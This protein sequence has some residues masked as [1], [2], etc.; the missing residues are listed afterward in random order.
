[1]QVSEGKLSAGRPAILLSVLSVPLLWFFYVPVESAVPELGDSDVEGERLKLLDSAFLCSGSICGVLGAK[2]LTVLAPLTTNIF[3]NIDQYG[4]AVFDEETDSDTLRSHVLFVRA[5][6][7]SLTIL[8][9]SL[10][11]FFHRC[12]KKTLL[13]IL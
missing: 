10:P 11:L 13:A 5:L 2:S 4:A 7:S 9:P 8:A 12:I 6:I 1:L 3:S